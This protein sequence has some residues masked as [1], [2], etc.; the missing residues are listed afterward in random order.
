MTDIQKKFFKRLALYKIQYIPAAIIP[1]IIWGILLEIVCSDCGTDELACFWGIGW[2]PSWFYIFN[3]VTYFYGKLLVRRY[4]PEIFSDIDPQL[5]E[6]HL[7]TDAKTF[8]EDFACLM[9]Y[10]KIGGIYPL[11]VIVLAAVIGMYWATAAAILC[12]FGYIAYRTNDSNDFCENHEFSRHGI[13][14]SG[15]TPNFGKINSAGHMSC[16]SHR[17]NGGFSGA[18]LGGSMFNHVFSDSGS[19]SARGGHGSF[20]WGMAHIE[21]TRE[22]CITGHIFCNRH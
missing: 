4:G 19:H 20:N 13:S 9:R 6:K 17:R 14:C 2:I 7:H 22:A 3:A 11:T 18:A 5:L 1:V 15:I 10:R 8:G 21:G 16:G 12:W